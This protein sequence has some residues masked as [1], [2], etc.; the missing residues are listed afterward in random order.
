MQQP[1]RLTRRSLL[2]RAAGLAVAGS[3]AAT[4]QVEEAGAGPKAVSSGA[5]SCILSPEMTEGPYYLRGEAVRRNIT[6]GKPGTALTLHL[7]VV[8][9]STCKPIKGAAVDV[10]HA[11]ATGV[12]SGVVGQTG[13]YLR[14][15][16]KSDAN[17]L[18]VFDTIYPGWYRGRAVH[19]HVKVHLGGN[20]VHTGQLFFPDA[21][22]DQV[23]KAAP[24]S[25][26]GN[27]DTTDASDSIYR[28]GG[29]KSLLSLK[30]SGS[31]YVGSIV[32][33]VHTG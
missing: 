29:S 13:T 30:K 12:Y 22:S 19:I 23:Y 32:M 20:V 26:R 9:A 6:E 7:T 3:A 2:Y 15:I 14:G 28:N 17:G 31:G 27:P 16:Q 10:W 21:L 8:N 33:G 11:D 24:Y 25:S 18:A 1:D 5:V 4:W